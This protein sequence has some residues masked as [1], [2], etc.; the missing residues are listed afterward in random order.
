MIK[1]KTWLCGLQDFNKKENYLEKSKK[2]AK[3]IR[4]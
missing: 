4:K 1:L 3:L 2:L